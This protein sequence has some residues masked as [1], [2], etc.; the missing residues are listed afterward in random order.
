MR[1]GQMNVAYRLR[2]IAGIKNMRSI[3]PRNYGSYYTRN[4]VH[5][6]EFNKFTCTEVQRGAIDKKTCTEVQRD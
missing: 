6:V 5:R 4:T 2:A 1:Y 3:E